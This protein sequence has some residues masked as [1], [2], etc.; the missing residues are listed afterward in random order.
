MTLDEKIGQMTQ[1]SGSL[2]EY[3]SMIEEGKIGSL[4]NVYGASETNRLQ[5][6]AV[7][8]SRLGIP[9]IFGLDVIHGYRTIFPIPLGSAAS[10]DTAFVRKAESIA[11]REASSEGIN[12]TFALMV[13]IARDPRWGR[14][15]EG[16]EDSFLGSTMARAQVLG[17]Q[18]K[19]LANPLTILACGKHFVAY[20]GAEG[21]RDYNTVDVSERTLREIYLPPFKAAVDA[22]AGSIMSAFNEINGIPASANRFTLTDI[23]RGEW[24]FNGFVV[25]DWNSIGELV[26]HGIASDKVGAGIE[27]LKAGVDMDMEGSA[28][29]ELLENEDN[30][31]ELIDNAVRRILREKFQLGLFEHPYIDE[32]LSNKLIL[33]DEH[34]KTALQLARESIV[35]LKN[36]NALLPLSKNLKSVAVIGPL[37]DDKNAPLGTWACVGKSENVVTVLEGIKKS[38]SENT[39]VYYSKGCG[40]SSD[41]TEMIE[42]SVKIAKKAGV[43]I[44]VVVETAKM[45]GEAASRSDLNLPGV[46]RDLIKAIYKTGMPIVVVL[47]NGRPLTIPWIKENVSSILEAWY[48]GI[49]SGNA[50]ADVLFGKYNPSGKLTVT[51]PRTVG[52]IPIYY[53]HKNSGRPNNPSD[54]FTSKYIDLSSSPLFTLG[55]GLSYTKFK[56]SNIRVSSKK[57]TSSESLIISVDVKNVGDRQGVEIVQ[58]YIHDVVA[59]VTRPVKELKGFRR[60][61]LDANEKKRVEFILKPENLGFYDQN[62]EYVIELGR[63]EI[64]VGGNSVDLLRTSFEVIE[65]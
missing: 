12:W 63:F 25:S 60:I 49:Q 5:K 42:E 24:G 61:S 62:M 14:I 59:S 31:K 18:G 10:W 35:L 17:F 7:E 52:Q 50:I 30:N 65:K 51:F 3:E 43:A 9:L 53:N 36:D 23:L 27:A 46:Q 11:A 19:S 47:L 57:I 32:N 64:M 13:D 45:S 37:A 48:L 39:Q 56:Y 22:G 29:L 15:A 44:I 28:Y 41:N 54:K 21:G 58:L 38:V 20:G 8:E 4:L 2:P 34:L 40:V 33:N 6:I 55:Y 1:F 16:G 26:K